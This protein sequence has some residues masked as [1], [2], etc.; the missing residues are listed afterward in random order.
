[1]RAPY[2]S[3]ESRYD[4]ETIGFGERVTVHGS[5]IPARLQGRIGI[6]VRRDGERWLAT[7]CDV[8][9]G[10]RMA[11]AL[12]GLAPCPAPGVRIHRLTVDR[13][14]VSL[15]IRLR[16]DVTSVRL[17]WAD[18]TRRRTFEPGVVAF[19]EVLRFPSAGRKTIRVRASGA[20][21]PGCGTDRP[22]RARARRTV[23]LD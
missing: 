5:R 22:S 6:V 21:G 19:G 15:R 7:R 14:S 23:V 3:A 13:R 16:G 2:L 20:A 4:E 1:M 17:R 10:A 18:K 8:V 11:N 12:S 9:P